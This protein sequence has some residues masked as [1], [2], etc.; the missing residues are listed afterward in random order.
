MAE[1]FAAAAK[2]GVGDRRLISVRIGR[3]DVGQ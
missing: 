3:H 1:Y 2:C